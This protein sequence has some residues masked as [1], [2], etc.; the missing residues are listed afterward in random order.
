[1]KQFHLKQAEIRKKASEDEY[2]RDLH[3]AS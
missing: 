1:L 2:V 3:E